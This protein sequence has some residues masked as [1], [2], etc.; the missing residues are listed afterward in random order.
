MARS[1]SSRKAKKSTDAV[2]RC[3]RRTPGEEITQKRKGELRPSFRE[4]TCG[5]TAGA[6]HAADRMPEV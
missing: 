2:M 3:R 5:R 6:P 1:A 4:T